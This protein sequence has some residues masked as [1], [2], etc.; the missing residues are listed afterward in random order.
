SELSNIN[1]TMIYTSVWEVNF[2]AT[3]D[4]G[5]TLAYHPVTFYYNYTDH[6]Y[7]VSG[8]LVEDS[9][10]KNLTARIPI[11]VTWTTEG[12]Y[13]LRVYWDNE[14]LTINKINDVDGSIVTY[15]SVGETESTTYLL[16][17]L[18]IPTAV[19]AVDD[20]TPG[21]GVGYLN[22]ST[23]VY[24]LNIQLKDWFGGSINATTSGYSI[25]K[26]S[27]YDKNDPSKLLATSLADS[28]GVVSFHQYPNVSSVLT[29][30]WLIHEI[31]VN[32]TEIPKPSE[33]SDAPM[34][35]YCQLVPFNI[36]LWDKRPSPGKL[37]NAKVK[38]TWPNLIEFNTRSDESLGLIQLPPLTSESP[39]TSMYVTSS[40]EENAA[41]YLPF[42]T[43]KIEIYWSITPEDP[44][45]WVK[46]RTANFKLENASNNHGSVNFWVD[47][48][49]KLSA[50][51]NV[52]TYDLICDVYD[53]HIALTDLNG[54]P[55]VSPMVVLEHPSGAVSTIRATPTGTLTLIQ[56]PGGVWHIGAVYKHLQ[57]KPYD[58][59]DIF[60]VTTNIY[61]AEEFKFGFVDANL[62]MVKW[63]TDDYGIENLN[64]TL[65]WEGNATI[66]GETGNCTEGPKITGSNGSVK[67]VQV[68]VGVPIAV[69]TVAD[70]DILT[71]AALREDADVGPYENSITLAPE[72]Y[73]G[74]HHVYIY[75]FVL[76]LCDVNGNPLP[77][78]LPYTNASL[79]MIGGD[80]YG[81]WTH[82]NSIEYYSINNKH[83]YVGGVEDTYNVTIYWAGVR[84]FNGSIIVPVVKDTSVTM[85]EI[86]VDLRV[87]PVTFDLYNWKHTETI[88]YLNVT[89]KWFGVNM[90]WLNNT[91]YPAYAGT[92][93]DLE[94]KIRKAIF[95][96]TSTFESV[97]NITY[98]KEIC[99]PNETLIYVPVWSIG[100]V[101]GT[102]LMIYVET[103]PGVTKDV[104]SNASSFIAG[105]LTTTG[106][107]INGTV[108][109][110]TNAVKEIKEDRYGI[111]NFTGAATHW[112]DI[113]SYDNDS[114]TFDMKVTA[115]D[116]SAVVK[117]WLDKGLEGFTVDVYWV[118]NVSKPLKLTSSITDENGSATFDIIFWGNTTTYRFLAY[119]EPDENE[120]PSDVMAKF[121]LAEDVI[122]ELDATVT[123]PPEKPVEL[124][125]DNYIGLQVLS[126]TGR[127]LYHSFDDSVKRALVYAVRYK[128]MSDPRTGDSVPAGTVAAFGYVDEHG[129]VYL[130]FAKSGDETYQYTIRARWM[131]VSVYDSYDKEI[132]TYK[133]LSPTIFYTAFTDVFDVSIRLVDDMSRPL[134]GVYYTFAGKG[135]N[136]YSMS[137]QTI[138]DGT[139]TAI[140]VPKGDYSLK[141]VW[142]DGKIQILDS[143]ITVDTNIVEHPIKC[144]VYDATLN[145]KTP[146]GTVLKAADIA[147]TYPDGKSYTGTTDA[148]GNILFTQIPIGD[149]TINNVTWMDA[150]INVAPTTVNVTTVHVDKSGT[151]YLVAQN[152]HLLTV[153]IYGTRG[154]GLGPST[155]SIAPVNV[156]VEADESGV[157]VV[158]LPAGSYTVH[159]NY[160]GIE[161]EKSVSLTADTTAEFKLDV[162]ATI[163]GRPFRTAEFFGELV[164][165]PI[166]LA[167]IIYLVA[168]EYYAWRR[169]RMAVVPPPSPS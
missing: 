138:A 113:W 37:L 19:G 69:D 114:L 153:K 24:P 66:T 116:M 62:T 161:A 152:V 112:Y 98:V 85:P 34:D 33:V 81:N 128:P 147:V 141:A 60:N 84:V 6:E 49:K 42:G 10:S 35:V 8:M 41:G 21:V 68:P 46:V 127:V 97:E 88:H 99:V 65:T 80:R 156:D 75:D 89:A 53:A 48:V 56:V 90:T 136:E 61:A 7:S 2:T 145:L 18:S 5:D 94:D 67:F 102:P 45:S 164:L 86:K 76:R 123:A 26:V 43:S 158:E 13:T 119:R 120:L 16:F 107:F 132:M 78:T 168:Y 29:V 44:N 47:D 149:L 32:T 144:K 59:S 79:Y 162:F 96:N 106:K 142:T 151:Y 39:A 124:T 4:S 23:A 52:I 51:S 87:Y 27:L 93:T 20:V 143:D 22:V 70:K 71:H 83:L 135:V 36:T 159:V 92:F 146:R 118:S 12:N 73:F 82:I 134:K 31:P 125:F 15:P 131:G 14:Y 129:Y 130:P 165:L 155:V 58:M 160:K 169:R 17:K 163:F 108:T 157:A 38:I 111:L 150:S 137:G 103:N 28:S 25:I 140:L 101:T 72:N 74:T 95:N 154:Q 110:K 30:Y 77:E 133:I 166:V 117:N 50:T 100:N 121:Q 139:F 109:D 148:D 167:I 11:D 91:I 105:C 9:Q 55:L 1:N 126:A 104:P 122:K 3:D 115:Y 64:V 40:S 63:G 54:N 57:V